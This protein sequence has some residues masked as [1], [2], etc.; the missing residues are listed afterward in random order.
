MPV[1]KKSRRRR[2]QDAATGNSAGQRRT[3]AP[4]AK[5]PDS[6][7]ATRVT[8]SVTTGTPVITGGPIII[9]PNL[10]I[11]SVDPVGNFFDPGR[12]GNAVVRPDDLVALRIELHN[13][14]VQ[15]G[16]PP[17]LK[18][19]GGGAAHLV[20]HFPPQAI[21]EQTFFER[22]PEGADSETTGLGS[23][24]LTGPPVR[25]RISG[26]SRLAFTVP[27]GFDVPYTL[28]GVLAAVEELAL[29]VPANAKPPGTRG[30]FASVGELFAAD[31]SKLS[32]AQRAALSNYAVRTLR[33]AAVQGDMA[34]VQLRQ[35]SGGKGLRTL[36]AS[37]V[38]KVVIDVG[39]TPG[40][41]IARPTISSR[42]ALP[43]SR[44]TAIELPWRLILSPHSAERWRHAKTPVTSPATQRTELWHSRLVAPKSDGSFIEPP[45]PD[46]QRTVRAVWA[47]TG[48]G[49][50]QPM[51]GTFPATL[52]PPNAIPF[53][54][55]LEDFDRFQFVHLSSNFSSRK[56]APTAVGVNLL[57][58]S[59]L[60]GWLDSRGAWDPPAGLS[61]EEWVHRAA[62]ARDHYV[63]VVYK[64]F[65][66]PLGHRVAL[67]KVSERKFHN[68]ARDDDNQPTIE[69]K[70]G[71]TAYLRQRFFIIIRER[72]RRF[73]DPN[74]T[75][76]A[77][78]VYYQFQLPFSS[79]RILT[80]V[81]PNLDP[82]NESPSE[83]NGLGQ[84]MFWPHVNG[85]PFR[86][87]CAATDVDGRTVQ[88]ELPMIFLDN[89]LVNPGP[90]SSAPNYATAE[91]HAQTAKTDWLARAGLRVAQLKQQ[92]VAL[93]QSVKAGDTTVQVQEMSFDAEVESGNAK[94]RTYSAE[95]SRPIFYPK[96]DEARVSIAA[97]AQLTGSAKTNK[98]KWNAFYL[99]HGF[100]SAN[101]GQV[102]VD[103]VS[104]SDMA[105]LDFSTQGDRS[106]GFVQPNLKPGAISRLAG[107][108]SGDAQT[109]QSFIQGTFTGADAFPGGLSDLPLPLLFGCIPLGDVIEQV[110]ALSGKPDKIPKFASEAST[111]IED[112]INGLGR[113]LDFISK[114]SDQP[115]S[116]ASGAIEA[117]KNT[118]QDL[119]DQAQAYAAPLVA[120][121][122]SRI[123]QLVT[124]LNAL[125]TQVQSLVNTTIDVA[126]PL[127]ALPGAI[128][129][130]QTAVT[131][132]RNA[133]NAQVGGVSLPAGLRQSVLQVANQLDAFAG[134]LATVTALINQGK[135]LYAAL[136]DIVGQPAQLG[137]LLSDPAQLKPKLQGVQTAITPLRATLAGFKLLEGAPRK[138][139]LD[140]IDV[141]LQVL[142][143]AADLL[144]LLEMLTGDELTIRFDWNP[145]IANWAL[146][147]VDPNTD[148]L[149]RANDK[150]GFLVAVEAKVKKNGQS[151]PKIGV[152]CSLKQFDL[153]LIAPA[154][155]IELNFEKI[156]FRV[157]SG[158]KMDVDVLLTD[159]KFVG[160]LSFVETLR[161]LIPLDGFS[162][163]P[164]LDITPQG[165][166]AGFSIALPN[167]SVGVFN[168]GNLSLGAGFTVP[169]IGQPLAVRFNFCTREQPF[170]L[171]VSLFGGGGFFGITLDPHGIQIL[172]AAFEF[173][174]S[175]SIDFGVA[176]GGVHVMAGVY[177]RMENDA[178]SLTGYFRLGGHVDVLGLI[179]ASLELYLELRYEFETGKCAGKA[180][181]TIEVEVFVFSG[182]VTI[183]CERK[184]AGSNGDP[185]FRELM[186][187]DPALPLANELAAIDNSTKY[188]WREYCEAFA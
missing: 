50:T 49:S 61:V 183:T 32:A 160:P 180:Q 74:L 173:G 66:F 139:V 76:K 92:R 171:T 64:G 22:N 155:F 146:P 124:A 163:P 129:G 72:E 42:P 125:L 46:N 143:A 77:G 153:V 118:L 79:V 51:Q 11:F 85:Q 73:V 170:N 65:L 145:T 110:T 106:G 40:P 26:E 179:S 158:A 132:L 114:L 21:T 30:S 166:D 31:I 63:R 28:E 134:D 36:R 19:T 112:F 20:L 53:L 9:D 56:Y 128:S 185:T 2:T 182:S 18:K 8:A 152:V 95:L 144:N 169:F 24:A 120:D 138:A 70:S 59:A 43:G 23:D 150:K 98:V 52:P 94:L 156:E 103:V 25:A 116:I 83:V 1:K 104:E 184:F 175:I 6:T 131:N 68:G 91:G 181:L 45:R 142:G 69:Q 121:V 157:D 16:S 54:M 15:P 176:S 89:T 96:V 12:P 154:S 136:D 80:A 60:G 17:R 162:D 177:F 127:P 141:V 86:F 38:D 78:D 102:F 88:F 100:K 62:M 188:P 97:L 3:R 44:H 119:L 159:I 165:I 107:P 130:V 71:N 58:L 147:G 117:A 113:L 135:T 57:M 122:K 37:A 172:E 82:P 14:S 133:A 75:N 149:F 34:T 178:C 174:A 161:D 4:V 187:A 55:P 168:L 39:V 93:A 41:I 108:V 99:Q 167:I 101:E 84:T 148:P 47:L 81:T 164:F 7:S 115:G 35:A 140:A 87:Q 27:D 126:P 48:E 90:L 111:Q 33:I 67:V 13:L 5:R 10:P 109:V 151:A 29:S 105:Q 186:G 123:N 137:N